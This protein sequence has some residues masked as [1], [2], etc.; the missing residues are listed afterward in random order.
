MSFKFRTLLMTGLMAWGLNST[1]NAAFEI[2]ISEPGAVGSPIVITDGSPFDTTPPGDGVI[3]VNT[4]AL[5]GALLGGGFT[6]QFSSLGANS[7]S[8]LG[9]PFSTDAAT[10]AQSGSVERLAGAVGVSTLTILVTDNGYNFPSPPGFLDSSAS[11][12]WTNTSAATSRTFSSFY[13]QTDTMYG[14][15]QA[16][17]TLAFSPPVGLGP[18]STS[19]TALTTALSPQAIPF[20]LTNRTVVTLVRTDAGDAGA[21]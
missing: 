16:S 6:F 2:T 8:T 15:A 7:N 20:S 9:V 19:G 18:F 12:T 13:D 4:F 5:N 21:S 3:N 10:L 14:M 17:P 11:D 1:A